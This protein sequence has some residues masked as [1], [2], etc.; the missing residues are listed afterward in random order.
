MTT[1]REMDAA[2]RARAG[3]ATIA[4]ATAA[5]ADWRPATAHEHKVK[6]SG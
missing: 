5:V 2:V 1:A 3:D 6:K 4:I